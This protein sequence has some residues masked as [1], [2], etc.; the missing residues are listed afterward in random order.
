[1]E[2][3]FLTSYE[4]EFYKKGK[5]EKR[6]EK[7]LVRSEILNVLDIEIT[8]QLET[9]EYVTDT[10]LGHLVKASLLDAL[11]R[12]SLKN[13]LDLTELLGENRKDV[14]VNVQG[15]KELFGD[16]LSDDKGLDN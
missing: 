5:R 6:I 2:N 13:L 1:M 9:G 15:A 4:T 12:P 7:A 10:F 8:K 11:Q 3:K 14:N 16:I